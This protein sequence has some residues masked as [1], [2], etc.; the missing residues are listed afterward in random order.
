MTEAHATLDLRPAV[1][2]DAEF[3]FRLTEACMRR[4]AEQTWGQWNEALT[5]DSFVPATHQIIQYGGEDIGCVELIESSDELRLAK[6]YIWP[7]YQNQGRNA[8]DGRDC[9]R[10]A[11]QAKAASPFRPRRQSGT[12]IL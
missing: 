6:L 10:R 12:S 2:A 7:D 4:Y 9:C 3:V 5:R 1:P 8:P 11:H